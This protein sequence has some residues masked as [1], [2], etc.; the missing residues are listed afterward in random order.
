M[1]NSRWLAE[2]EASYA[3]FG[4]PR[5][6]YHS[7]ILVRVQKS[8]KPQ[9]IM[10][11]F[12]NIWYND[13]GFL[14]VVRRSWEVHVRGCLLFQVVQKMKILKGYLKDLNKA[15]Y[16]NLQGKRDTALEALKQK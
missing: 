2:F 10:F 16:T 11:K 7:P 13:E 9:N 3:E 4:E 8:K 15:A 5:V 14:D 12:K 6:S 1:V